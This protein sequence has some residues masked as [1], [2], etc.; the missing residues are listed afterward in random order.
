MSAREADGWVL[1]KKHAGPLACERVAFLCSPGVPRPRAELLLPDYGSRPARA[2]VDSLT[3]SAGHPPRT[4]A[5]G[6]SQGAE[7]A[8]RD[9]LVPAP[10]RPRSAPGRN[11]VG[12]DVPN[13]TRPL[14]EAPPWLVIGLLI[15]GSV[16]MLAS[17]SALDT[18]PTQGDRR[19]SAYVQH[20]GLDP[21]RGWA[22][23]DMRVYEGLFREDLAAWV[24]ERFNIPMDRATMVVNLS[25]EF[26]CPDAV[27][28]AATSSLGSGST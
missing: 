5:I 17:T 6:M 20:G 27:P 14:R 11:L 18:E 25:G 4:I 3:P 23:C 10:H 13:W 1:V 2:A 7:E 21:S 8:R 26:L 12:V 24:V 9:P 22:A 16:F 28:R 15:A 19:E